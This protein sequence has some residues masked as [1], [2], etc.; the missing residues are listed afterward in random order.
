MFTET[1]FPDYLAYGLVTGPRFVTD[2]VRRRSGYENRNAVWSAELLFFDGATTVRTPQERLEIDS[3]FRAVARGRLNGFRVRNYGDA[4]AASTEGLLGSGVGTGLP[5]YQLYKRYSAGGLNSDKKISKPVSGAVT[6]YRNA[7]P[8][9]IGAGAG[10]IGIDYTSG[11]VTFVADNTAS[12]N[13]ITPGATTTVQLV[14]NLG[15][16]GAGQLLYLTGFTGADAALV[17]DLAHVINS[18]SGA[19]PYDYVL[20]T[21]TSGKTITTG[22]G[23]GRRYPQAADALTWAGEFDVP[24]RFDHDELEWELVDRAGSGGYWFQARTLRMVE[25]RL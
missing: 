1:R 21:D 25:L 16:L 3:F 10:Q 24:V 11:L 4:S 8:V 22:S 20:A 13:S 9:T 5:G 18:V 15:G 23:E 14:N 17:N 19:G 7:S 12:A 6:V 2:V